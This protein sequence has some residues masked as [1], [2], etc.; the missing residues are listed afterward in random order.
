MKKTILVSV[1]KM[2]YLN[3]MLIHGIFAIA[4]KS[5]AA[6]VILNRRTILNGKILK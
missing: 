2:K 4:K 5:F 6:V 3:A 1:L